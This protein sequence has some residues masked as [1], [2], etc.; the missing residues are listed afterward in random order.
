M[1][2]LAW[3]VLALSCAAAPALARAADGY[4]IANVN[5]RA[6]PDISYPRIDTIPLGTRVDIRG[7]IDG[8]EWCDVVVFGIHGWIAGTFLQYEYQSRPVIVEEYGARIGIPIITFVIGTYWGNYYRDRPFYRQRDYWYHRHVVRR[9]P[10]R[11]IH[12]PPHPVQPLAR[13]SRPAIVQP[14]PGHRPPPSQEHRP[15]P[16]QSQRPRPQTRPSPTRERKE[17][18]KKD[19]GH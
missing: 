16:G 10:P 13:P 5:L 11:A 9:P 1:K 12:R 19:H 17:E 4:V 14:S 3:L 18:R 8:W 15:P 7:C 6:G 2:R